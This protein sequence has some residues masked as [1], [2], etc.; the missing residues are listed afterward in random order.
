MCNE[1]VLPVEQSACPTSRLPAHL[2][3]RSSL[4]DSLWG[5]KDLNNEIVPPVVSYATVGIIAAA[6]IHKKRDRTLAEEDFLLHFTLLA[7]LLFCYIRGHTNGES[8]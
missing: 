7:A 3:A 4:S 1:I 8:G 6:R 2:S 5:M